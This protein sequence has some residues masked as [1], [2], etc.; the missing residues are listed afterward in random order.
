M[1]EYSSSVCKRNNHY[2]DSLL[3]CFDKTDHAEEKI[4]LLELAARIECNNVTGRLLDSRIEER[5][6]DLSMNYR[7]NCGA[8]SNQHVLHILSRCYEKGGHTRLTKHVIEGDPDHVHS[9]CIVHPYH[10]TIP[11][12]LESAV[13]SSGGRVFLIEEAD[14]EK[15]IRKIV[16]LLRQFSTAYCYFHPWDVVSAIAVAARSASCTAYFYNHTDHMFNVG[17][18]ACDYILD[19]SEEG[20]FITNNYRHPGK[21]VVLPIPID[22]RIADAKKNRTLIRKEYNIPLDA[23]VVLSIA[24][25]E[26]Y[27]VNDLYSFDSFMEALLSHPEV[28]IVLV[29]PNPQKKRWEAYKK[30]YGNRVVLTGILN[31]EDYER[32]FSVAD[33]YVD[34]FP[35][36]SATCTL[37]ALMHGLPAFSLR[38]PEAYV[39]EISEIKCDSVDDVTEHVLMALNGSVSYNIDR[40]LN[41]VEKGHCEPYWGNKLRAIYNDPKACITC[42]HASFDINDYYNY[43][44]NVF[45]GKHFILKRD[46]V[47]NLKRTVL[48]Q[49]VGILK[50]DFMGGLLRSAITLFR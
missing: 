8:E 20:A 7:E 43:M 4:E 47:R 34:S 23:K 28:V 5:I 50:L 15:K 38:I 27:K 9:L 14:R 1:S 16:G 3:Q 22:L 26:K 6:H 35:M 13:K 42:G 45:V 18:T 19:M 49:L 2:I 24:T 44:E 41:G 36:D 30:K 10:V 40:L 11:E 21:S 31:K 37:D 29:G 33:C 48:F 39:D 17:C 32:I 46:D 12:W 25:E